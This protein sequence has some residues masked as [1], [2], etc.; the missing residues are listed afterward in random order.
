MGGENKKIYGGK[1]MRI[2]IH[3][4]VMEVVSAVAITQKFLTVSGKL[5]TVTRKCRNLS[6]AN[7]LSIEGNGIG[8]SVVIGNIS[9]DKVEELLDR[10]GNE[11]CVNL[12]EFDV[13]RRKKDIGEG[14]AYAYISGFV[15]GN[16]YVGA[17]APRAGM[18]PPTVFPRWDEEEFETEFDEFDYEGD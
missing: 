12:D 14:I 5:K 15:E 1:I 3:E 9:P 13:V 4:Y 17:F 8:L 10:I 6:E 16:D 11:P 2:K 7:G 18:M